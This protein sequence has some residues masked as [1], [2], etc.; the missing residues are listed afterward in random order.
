MK[1]RGLL[2][3]FTSCILVTLGNAQTRCAYNISSAITT[4]TNISVINFVGHNA[5]PSAIDA[6]ISI[7]AYGCGGYASLFPELTQSNAPVN[8]YRTM[9]VDVTFHSGRSTLAS[10]RC[11]ETQVQIS[12]GHVSGATIDMWEQQADGTD[13]TASYGDLVAHEIG[14]A[15]GLGDVDSISACDYTVMGAKLGSPSNDQCDQ[16]DQNWETSTETQRGPG[17]GNGGC[18]YSCQEGRGADSPIVINFEN[19]GYRLTGTNAPVLFDIDATGHA[20]W[21]GWTAAGTSEA[22]LAL[23]RDGDGAITSGAEM[24]GNATPLESGQRAANGFD[25]LAEFDDNHDGVI[26]SRDT[27]WSS[28]LL[29]TDL[30]HDGVSQPSEL[31]PLNGSSVLAISLAYHWTGRRDPSGNT[32]RY[33]SQVWIVN[34]AGHAAA[35][36]LYDIFFAPLQ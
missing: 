10:G 8:N 7:W 26:D 13:C 34:S 1:S 23:D 14:H 25:A 6:A 33:Q 21:I 32:F 31:R 22:F 9:N 12:N 3:L 16:A 4:A 27:I 18:G 17:P 15:F 29:W 19:G 36:P 28:L 24:F 35:R 2:L 5:P 11:G 30:N 20:F